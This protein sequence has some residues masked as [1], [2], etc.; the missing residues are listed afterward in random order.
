[1]ALALDLGTLNK[2]LKREK[3]KQGDIT[4]SLIWNDPSDLDIFAYVTLKGGR[5]VTIG[6][7]DGVMKAHSAEGGTLDVDANGGGSHLDSHSVTLQPVENIYWKEPPPGRYEIRVNNCGTRS[8]STKWGGKFTNPRRAVPF[9]CFLHKDGKM[10]TFDG[11]AKEHGRFASTPTKWKPSGTVLCFKFEVKSDTAGSGAG[12]GGSAGGNFIVF[13]PEA[14]KTSFKA[15]CAKHGVAWK[16]GNGFYAVARPETI[17]SYKEMVL[18]KI[19]ANTFTVGQTNCRKAL[20]WPSG[21]LKKGPKDIKAGYRLF[22]QS[23]SATRVIPP[24]THVLFKATAEEYAKFRKTKTVQS[25]PHAVGKKG[26]SAAAKKA[27][28]KAGMKAVPRVAA[29]AQAKSRAAAKIGA[30]RAAP[31]K[32]A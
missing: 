20:G 14:S 1:M 24:G 3:A 28:M 8:H 21:G 10:Q 17:Q 13:P 6:A 27:A 23:T 29:K 5:K 30:K 26:L 7:D 25:D 4:A 16:Q 9:K 32:V 11:A 12:G 2:R 31:R 19:S 15:L 22:V 18:H